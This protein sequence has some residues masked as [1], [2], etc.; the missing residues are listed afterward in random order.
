MSIKH[1]KLLFFVLLAQTAS[2]QPNSPLS[3]Q[4]SAYKQCIQAGITARESKERIET[5][6]SSEQAALIASM[7]ETQRE[8]GKRDANLLIIQE[9]GIAGLR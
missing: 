4:L 6:C 7:P 1:S 3:P 9:M 2:A 5:R 8:R